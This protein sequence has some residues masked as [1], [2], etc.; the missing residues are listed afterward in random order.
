MIQSKQTNKTDGTW[1]E[2]YD[3]CRDEAARKLR[4]K[5]RFYAIEHDLTKGGAISSIV[6]PYGTGENMLADPMSC[7]IVSA[8]G[9]AFSDLYDT[10]PT[11]TVETA[12]GTVVVVMEGTLCEKPKS[13]GSSDGLKRD[14]DAVKYRTTFDYRWGYIRI[15]REFLFPETGF[16]VSQILVHEWKL[17][18]DI[19]HFGVRAGSPAYDPTYCGECQWGHFKPGQAYDYPY[20]SN[21]VP[22]HVVFGNPGREGIEWFSSSDLAQWTHDVCGEAGHG[23]LFI[24]P[25]SDPKNAVLFQVSALK[26]PRADLRL[27]EA[28]FNKPLTFDF[29]IGIPILSGQ[30]PRPFMH[31]SFMRNDWP[32][33]TTIQSWAARG[34]RTAH[35]HHDGDTH[36]DGLFWRDGVYPPFGPEDMQSFDRVLDTCRRNGIR[37]TTYF[38]N[39]ELH[40]VTEA[41]QKHGQEWARLPDGKNQVHNLYE[42]DEYGAQ[43]CLRSGWLDAFKDNVETVMKHHRLDG[44]YYDWNQAIYCNNPA[45]SER[46]CPN[47]Q[48]DDSGKLF[49]DMKDSPVAHWDID[50]LIELMEWTRQRVGP[51]GMVIIHNTMNPCMATENF[52]DYILGMEWGSGKL[53]DGAPALKDLPFEWSFVGARTRGVIT[54][55]CLEKAASEALHRKRNI[56][57]LLTGVS[58]WRADDVSLEMFGPLVSQNLDG[59]RFLDWRHGVA[60][61]DHPAI[62]SAAYDRP[63]CAWLLLANLSDQS[64]KIPVM[65]SSAAL[66]LRES[67]HYGLTDLGGGKTEQLHAT[68]L[69]EKGWTT[70]LLANTCRFIKIEP[71]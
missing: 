4:L 64:I 55:G 12:D 38:S 47:G 45:H 68:T 31:A 23:G 67:E 40:P 1:P 61:S 8:G 44:I 13:G 5:T 49:A 65:L 50:E 10:D 29:R 42:G 54:G 59:C 18:R 30:A 25:Q 17:R 53:S 9:V 58:P 60:V 46:E 62:A 48:F 27:Q 11:C 7:E 3:V 36:H 66:H 57:C 16:S 43:M 26:M 28:V 24:C 63:D 71:V 69:F 33:E 41:Y 21:Y 37:V 15:R 56:H 39:K 32:S 14:G 51:E 20:F 35:F 34:V 52:A 22:R 70:L 6:L 2:K 19:G